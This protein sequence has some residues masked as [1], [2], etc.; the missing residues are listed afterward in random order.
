[1]KK[2]LSALIIFISASLLF[3]E[4]PIVQDIQAM[5]GKNNRI[6]IFWALPENPDEE[7][8]SLQIYRSNK[9]ITS[10]SQIASL[11][12]LASLAP[13]FTGY[14]DIVPD[15]NEYF[16]AVIAVTK[17][18]YDLILLS[19]NSTVNGVKVTTEIKRR[20]PKKTEY[21]KFYPDGSMR[22]TPLP[23]IDFVENTDKEK[24]RLIS[25]KTISA[26][27]SLTSKTSKKTA[28]LNPYVFEEDLISPDGG[29]DYLLF[30][31]LKNYFVQQNYEETVSQIQKLTG[32]NI[33][34]ST[35][36]R[37]FFYLGESEYFLGHY[38][39]AVKT[40]VKVEHAYPTLVKKWLDSSL[41]RL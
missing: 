40:F 11:N 9:Q 2:F 34:E 16:Y 29:D 27:N 4:R 12:P 25:D 35:R 38:E 28:S 36:N 31:I 8:T 22:E 24:D 19:F 33:N 13:D 5:P 3:A 10:Y 39:N 14:T 32:T 30:E 7:I 1:M 37:A 23:Y 15:M 17:A 20:E 21:E 41:D 6:N 18:P 26:T